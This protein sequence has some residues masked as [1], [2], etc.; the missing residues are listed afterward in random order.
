[1]AIALDVTKRITPAQPAKS[2]S[3]KWEAK[4]DQEKDKYW[5][6]TLKW[7]QKALAEKTPDK[8]NMRKTG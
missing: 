2:R 1:M 4:F 8:S 5:A 7:Q 6:G 3:A